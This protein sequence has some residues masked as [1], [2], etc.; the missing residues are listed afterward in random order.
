MTAV[1]DVRASP[2]QLVATLPDTGN[3][4]EFP[5][6]LCIS[7]V[8]IRDQGDAATV[9]Q[10]FNELHM[11]QWPGTPARI[12]ADAWRLHEATFRGIRY[13]YEVRVSDAGLVL[14]GR[15]RHERIRPR[16]R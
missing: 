1:V 6:L 12:A 3:Y 2:P 4:T 8:H 9:W 11:K 15:L 10:A 14:S 13:F 5:E 16:A 7:G